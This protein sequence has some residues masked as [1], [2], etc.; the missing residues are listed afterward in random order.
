MLDGK[1]FFPET[2]MPMLKSAL[3]KVVF[4]VALPDPLIVQ[5]VIVKSLVTVFELGDT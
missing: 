3:S 5:H 4:A 2:G 1:I